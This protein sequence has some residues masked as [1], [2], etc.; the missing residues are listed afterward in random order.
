L[1]A[2]AQTSAQAVTILILNQAGFTVND[3]DGPFSAGGNAQAATVAFFLVN[4]DNL[5]NHAQHSLCIKLVLVNQE[6]GNRSQR[7]SNQ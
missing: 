5:S 6:P 4:L 2:F 1:G 7:V 3:L